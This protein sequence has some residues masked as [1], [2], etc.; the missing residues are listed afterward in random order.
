MIRGISGTTICNETRINKQNFISKYVDVLYDKGN[1]LESSGK[2]EE[3]IKNYD[4]ILDSAPDYVGAWYHK[5][6][7]CPHRYR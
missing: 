7:R 6:L 4:R 3:A 1:D 5:G 2:Y